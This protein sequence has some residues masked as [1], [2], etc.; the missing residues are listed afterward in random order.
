MT[1]NSDGTEDYI[2]ALLASYGE[3]NFPAVRDT[4]VTLLFAGREST[5]NTISWMMYELTRH[6]EWITLL[7]K[8]AQSQAALT[9][10]IIPAYSQLHVSKYP[11]RSVLLL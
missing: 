3:T 4:L 6:A 10:S 11:S 7:R 5:Q 2:A 1:N 8:E 9:G